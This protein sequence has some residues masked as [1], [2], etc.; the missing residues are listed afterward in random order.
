MVSMC[1]LS[2]TGYSTL[3]PQTNVAGY[4]DER[5]VNGS[6]ERTPNQSQ[7]QAN[8]RV[9]ND[10]IV[11]EQFLQC[12]VRSSQMVNPGR[13]IHQDH[14]STVCRAAAS[15][16]GSPPPESRIEGKGRCR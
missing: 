7:L 9:S 5:A 4:L 2:S 14:S 11:L 1:R 13:G 3:L 10:L 8:E 15:A 12:H 6:E 16:A